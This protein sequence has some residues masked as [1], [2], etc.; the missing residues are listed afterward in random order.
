MLHIKQPP[1]SMADK[2]EQLLGNNL[3]ADG[4]AKP[5]GLLST[6]GSCIAIISGMLLVM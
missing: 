3:L 1:Y 4:T 6:E 5:Q 2:G